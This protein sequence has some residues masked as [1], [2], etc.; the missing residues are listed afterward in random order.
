MSNPIGFSTKQPYVRD[1]A[2][3]VPISYNGSEFD[4]FT[5]TLSPSPDSKSYVLKII[6][7]GIPTTIRVNSILKVDLDSTQTQ[8]I[9]NFSMEYINSD[10]PNAN[11]I[12][13]IEQQKDCILF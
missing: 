11:V 1:A 8:N 10:Y 2:I 3:Y 7:V 5:T 6:H 13:K 4:T 12:I 9:K